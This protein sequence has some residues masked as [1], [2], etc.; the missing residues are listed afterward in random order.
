MDNVIYSFYKSFFS[1]R[2]IAET[3]IESYLSLEPVVHDPYEMVDMDIAVESAKR[4]IKEDK[5]VTIFGDYDV[6]GIS[7]TAL[8]SHY[9]RRCVTNVY[10]VIPS[11]KVGY[12]FIPLWVEKL[13]QEANRINPEKNV[14]LILVD[15]GSKSVEAVRA[16]S[17]KFDV[18][19]L[20]HHTIES[21]SETVHGL[22][23]TSALVNPMR[24]DCDYP[25]KSLCA[26]HLSYKFITALSEAMGN[27]ANSD[28]IK[29]V[30]LATL[31]TIADVMSLSELEN[32][33]LVRRGMEMMRGDFC[34]PG[35]EAVFSKK[36]I[37]KIS[38]S[39]ESIAFFVAPIINAWGR[40]DSPSPALR[41]LSFIDDKYRG[42]KDIVALAEE[43]SDVNNL[44]KDIQASAVSST[45]AVLSENGID[46]NSPNPPL[47]FLDIDAPT[48]ILGL[49]S[50]QIA[51]EYSRPTL[52]Y[53]ND[54]GIC[55]GSGRYN[56]GS[57]INLHDM[58]SSA[59]DLFSSY[60]GHQAAAGFKFDEKNAEAIFKRL[61]SYLQSVGYSPETIVSDDDY[62]FILE[63]K[64]IDDNM[65]AA[66]DDVYPFGVENFPSPKFLSTES[67]V[68]PSSARVFASKHMEFYVSDKY[69]NSFKVI[70]W[71]RSDLVDRVG[72]MSGEPISFIYKIELDSF[73]TKDM[74]YPIY[75]LL[76]ERIINVE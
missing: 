56:S 17:D 38:L 13:E 25:N 71:N 66:L 44:R 68:V 46:K 67:V 33:S 21:M 23:Q 41:L 73:N 50:A 49:I 8:L 24:P 47:L 52:V 76:L 31:A 30:Q 62:D 57:T 7:S 70:S 61:S 1:R 28:D 32:R 63:I 64:D 35:L 54:R 5:I 65:I 75:Q 12:G 19:V 39:I 43:G 26:G 55:T 60:G 72:E 27:K 20:D 45:M 37:S 15:N 69:G 2:G 74:N 22:P 36:W 11:R 16:L 59:G 14:F 29:Y 18:V 6:D 48:G 10:P 34:H 53:S 51:R 42:S 58:L 3:D 40:M 4:A 9:F